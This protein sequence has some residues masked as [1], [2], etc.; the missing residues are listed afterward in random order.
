MFLGA[1]PVTAA[2]DMREAVE[3]EVKLVNFSA[4]EQM[5]RDADRAYNP[6]AL[7]QLVDLFPYVW[8]LCL[9]SHLYNQI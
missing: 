2:K 5:R 9:F 3:L 8:N 6:F 1:D 7:E 4:D